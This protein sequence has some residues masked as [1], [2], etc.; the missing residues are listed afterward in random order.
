MFAAV[1]FSSSAAA[2]PFPES[3]LGLARE[4]ICELGHRRCEAV[5]ASN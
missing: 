1:A 3:N 2:K 4:A 5:G